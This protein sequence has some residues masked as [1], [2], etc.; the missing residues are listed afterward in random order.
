MSC[1]PTVEASLDFPEEEVE[2]L[3]QGRIFER[4][5]ALL[6]RIRTILATARRGSV[7]REGVTVALWGAPT[8]GSRAC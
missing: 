4:T 6:E 3:A 1:A 2:N 8:S 7:L 5:E